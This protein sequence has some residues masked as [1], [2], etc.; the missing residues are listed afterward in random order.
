M[1][2]VGIA[3]NMKQI[4]LSKGQFALVDDDDYDRL[5]LV[6]WSANNTGSNWYAVRRKGIGFEH[7]PRVIMN[8]PNNVHVY[9]LD[10]DGLNNRKSNLVVVTKQHTP[11]TK[12]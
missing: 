11:V 12:P 8:V 5:N 4:A 7:M 10:G 1:I 3:Y 2:I 6:K 9:H